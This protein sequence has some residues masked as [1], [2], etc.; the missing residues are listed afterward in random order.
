MW[1][2][3]NSECE[4]EEDDETLCDRTEVQIL[5]ECLDNDNSDEAI[6][7]SN[8]VL[9]ILFRSRQSAEMFAKQMNECVES[10]MSD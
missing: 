2:N 10:L 3:L 9:P 8:A 1:V 4:S 7:N 5:Q 6:K